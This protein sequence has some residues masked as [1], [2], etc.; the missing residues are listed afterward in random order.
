MQKTAWL[1]LFCEMIAV[2]ADVFQKL[3]VPLHSIKDSR[4]SDVS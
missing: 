4:K 1:F 3:I 2:I